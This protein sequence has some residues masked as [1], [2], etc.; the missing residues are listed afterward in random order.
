MGM[1]WEIVK[2]MLVISGLGSTDLILGQGSGAGDQ[3]DSS[4]TSASHLLCHWLSQLAGAVELGHPPLC[5]RL[6]SNLLL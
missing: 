3:E 2:Q 1:P 4:G 6:G 5:S